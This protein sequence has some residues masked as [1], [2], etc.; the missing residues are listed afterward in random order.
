[1]YCA[2]GLQAS[3]LGNRAAARMDRPC[4]CGILKPRS[5]MGRVP[6]IRDYLSGSKPRMRGFEP[7]WWI[8]CSRFKHCAMVLVLSAIGLIRKG[9]S[10]CHQVILRPTCAIPPRSGKALAKV[11][12]EAHSV[13]QIR[14]A[15]GQR[16]YEA[17]AQTGSYY[18]RRFTLDAGQSV[19]E[20]VATRFNAM[21]EGS[22]TFRQFGSLERPM[23][24]TR[25]ESRGS[26]PWPPQPTGCRPQ[27]PARPLDREPTLPQAPA[28]D[29]CAPPPTDIRSRRSGPLHSPPY[30]GHRERR[31]DESHLPRAQRP[32][33]CR[34]PASSAAAHAP[35]AAMLPLRRRASLRIF[36]VRCGLPCDPPV[37]GHSCNGAMIP[38]F[39][40]P[41]C[42]SGR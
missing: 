32:R 26:P 3:V 35:G 41:V 25:W 11:M 39:H 22:D 24:R 33:E 8:S 27:L 1:M 31:V 34:P 36:V 21:Y 40:R 9:Q 38:R 19:S 30:V 12:S 16:I 4:Q 23:S 28:A 10:Y 6:A 18:D 15:D 37:G 14:V 2:C 29:R 13:F 5:L 7:V 17:T 20:T 42:D